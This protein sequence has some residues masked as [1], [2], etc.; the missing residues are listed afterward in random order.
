M[1]RPLH[2]ISGSQHRKNFGRRT[3]PHE[4]RKVFTATATDTGSTAAALCHHDV[5]RWLHF[6]KKC[7]VW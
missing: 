3:P 2:Q 7:D 4:I 5:E 6:G 1:A